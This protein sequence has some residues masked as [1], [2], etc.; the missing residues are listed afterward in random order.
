[1]EITVTEFENSVVIALQGRLERAS[2]PELDKT[3]AA[4][5][6][7]GKYN[8]IVDMSQLEYI[9]SVGIRA[10]LTAQRDHQRAGRGQLMLVQVPAH[11]RE[12][13][14]V[15]GI[16]EL[17]RTFEDLPSAVEFAARLPG[18]PDIVPPL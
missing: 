13:L 16:T 14:E 17:F 7:R 12:A 2:I 3:L 5:N 10:L 9:S 15:T 11:I 18:D 8:L 6:Q 4:S 1:M